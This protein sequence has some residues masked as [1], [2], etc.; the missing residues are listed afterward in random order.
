MR[1]AL[2]VL[3]AAD[4]NGPAGPLGLLVI[5]LLGIAVFLLWRSM[6]KHLRRVPASFDPPP[7]DP[8]APPAGGE[9]D[10]PPRV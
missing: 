8:A 9:P 10:E 1:T 5:T 2:T 3:A 7:A 6:V 4:R